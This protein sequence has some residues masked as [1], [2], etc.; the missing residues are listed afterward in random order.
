MDFNSSLRQV[1]GIGEKTEK[2]FQKMGVYTAGDILFSFPRTYLEYPQLKTAEECTENEV[3]AVTASL[4]TPAVNKKTRS[5]VITLATAFSRQNTPMQLVWF[6]TP[7]MKNQL[8]VGQTVIFYGKIIKERNQWKMEQ[9]VVYTMEQYERI[10]RS[11]QPIYNLTAGL[12]NSVVKKT[13]EQVLQEITWPVDAIDSDLLQQRNLISFQQ[14]IQ[15]VHFPENFD[16]LAQGRQRLVYDE[17]F[18]FILQSQYHKEEIVQER[19]PWSITRYDEAGWVEKQLPFPLTRGQR[20]ALQDINRDFAGEYVSQRLIQGDVGS[21]KTIVAFLAMLTVLSNG[22]QAALM[23][24]TEVLTRQHYQ[25]FLE[26]IEEYKLPYDAVCL[27][28]S[29]TAKEK[30]AVYERIAMEES[31]FIIGTHALIQEKV[32]YNQLAL[33]ITDEQHRFGVKQRD[34][35]SEKGEHPFVLV[36]SATPIPRTLAMILYNDMNIS[37]ISDVPAKRLPIKNCVVGNTYH[38]TA[39]EFIENQVKQ[40]HQAYIICS[41]VEASEKTEAENV[42]EYAQRLR[43]YYQGRV[44]VGLLHG[45]QKANEKNETM[46][47]FARHEIDVLVS[48][49]VVEVGMNVPNATVMVIEDANRFGLAQLH[50]LRGRVGRGDAQSYC[51]M[52]NASDS[53]E[54]A[55]RL[56]ILNQSNDGFFIASE[57]LKLRGPGDFYGIRQS[58]DFNFQLGDIIGDANLLQEASEDVK[59]LLSQDPS[60]KLPKHKGLYDMLLYR[61]EKSYYA[62]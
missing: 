38:K 51:I 21:G 8:S 9:P 45:K 41:L 35:F 28:G 7:Y 53:K 30:R 4:R 44:S 3:C 18:F 19:N 23:A 50:Q 26:M 33:V 37:V 40:G 36:M 22:Y 5:V 43:A 57:D 55:K 27:T 47:A 31:L 42:T 59:H 14:G 34:A 32:H 62:I 25:S 46:E 10:R 12:N 54:S 52:F 39:Y 15:Q 17:F 48:T 11:L 60:L 49:T 24:P 6:R 58:G 16:A 61:M 2:L 56:E 1:K 13:V 29:M 20:G